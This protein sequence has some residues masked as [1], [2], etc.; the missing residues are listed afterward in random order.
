MEKLKTNSL[1]Q[2]ERAKSEIEELQAQVNQYH[3]STITAH[4]L[5]HHCPPS[6][7]QLN[8]AAT[9]R[10]NF[11]RQLD[12]KKDLPDSSVCLAEVQ[13]LH[14]ALRGDNKRLKAESA[15]LK[16]ECESFQ[17]RS[18]AAEAGNTDSLTKE[19]KAALEAKDSEVR[20]R[21]EGNE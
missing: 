1:T 2:H 16:G 5:H 21:R 20:E 3:H 17:K 18:E 12:E 15:R 8:S 13:K 11:K 9:L 6:L 19:L 10:D 7:P 14:T 4:S